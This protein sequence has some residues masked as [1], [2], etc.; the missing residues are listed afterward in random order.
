M[1]WLAWM[2]TLVWVTYLSRRLALNLEG[3]VKSD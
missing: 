3:D 1:L 2:G